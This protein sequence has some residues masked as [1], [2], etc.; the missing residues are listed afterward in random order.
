[1]TQVP[2]GG[3]ACRSRPRTIRSCLPLPRGGVP[4]A[5]EIAHSDRR[6]AR[7]ARR[8][9]GRRAAPQG[10]RDRRDCRGRRDRPRRGGDADGRSHRRS[11]SSSWRP[12]SGANWNVV[13]GCIA[14]TG[15]FRTLTDHDVVLV[16][17]GLATGVSAEAAIVALHRWRA[18]RVVLAAPVSAADTASRLAAKADVVCLVA[19]ARFSAVGDWYE[20]FDQTTDDEV[21]DCSTERG[22]RVTGLTSPAGGLQ[23]R[24]G[25]MSPKTKAMV[26]KVCRA[27]VWIVYAW[28]AI[29]IVL[30]FLAFLLQLFGADPSA[31]FVEFIYRSTASGDGAVP[32]HL[33]VRPA[34]GQLDARHLDPVRDHRLQLRCTRSRHRPRLGHAAS[35]TSPRTRPDYDAALEARLAAPRPASS[36]L[37]AA[38]G[39]DGAI[40]DRRAVGARQP[41]RTSTSPRAGSTRAART[42]CGR[43]TRA[44]AAHQR[45]QLPA[46]PSRRDQARTDERR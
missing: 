9:Q 1:M 19:P 5:F 45:R 6:A 36:H 7:R 30:L 32:G 35:S 8:A 15:R 27:L 46:E 12:T 22:R 39:T 31:G 16:D 20:D 41:A 38:R 21:L 25:A 26:I 44:G 14:A 28:V 42:R 3:A 11:S 2:T 33:R 4:V 24:G 37:A 18:R 17:D 43:R 13:F 10:V 23:A 34:V 29:T 40:G